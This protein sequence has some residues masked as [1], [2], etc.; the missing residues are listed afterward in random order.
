MIET[1]G[2]TVAGMS[3]AHCEAAVRAELLAVPGVTSVD[4]DLSTKQVVATGADLDD[5]VLRAAITEAGYEA[6]Q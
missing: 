1:R 3:C 2:Y 6:A 5:R 4:V